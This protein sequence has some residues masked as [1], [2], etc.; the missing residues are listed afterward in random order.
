MLLYFNQNQTFN[1]INTPFIALPFHNLMNLK[2][3]YDPRS[4]K[5][6]FGQPP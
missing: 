4:F 1:G 5:D 3:K 6:D 2:P